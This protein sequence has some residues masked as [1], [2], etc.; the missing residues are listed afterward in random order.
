MFEYCN[1][2][3]QAKLKLNREKADKAFSLSLH[4]K[5]TT[6][7][8]EESEPVKKA[9][10]NEERDVVM[11]D[12][13]EEAAALKEALSLSMHSSLPVPPHS[14]LQP[15]IDNA[16]GN[17][18]PHDF[19]GLYELHSLVTHKGRSADSGHYIGWARQSSD[20]TKSSDFWWCYND[21]K[22]SEVHTED[23]LKLSGGGDRD[24]AYLVFYKFKK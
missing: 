19:G 15:E 9:S 2:E 21:E 20:S 24:M 14:S 1:E 5:G 6:A 4:S 17:G 3:L 12:D 11:E 10:E 8:V 13:A 18:L 7:I 16:F 23:V 22:V